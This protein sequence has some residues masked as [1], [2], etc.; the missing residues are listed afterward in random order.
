MLKNEIGSSDSGMVKSSGI[1][2]DNESENSGV[3]PGNA[4]RDRII[5]V[6]DQKHNTI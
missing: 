3:P 5:T 1:P 6:R 2:P 4:V